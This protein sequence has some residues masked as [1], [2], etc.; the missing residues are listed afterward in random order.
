MVHHE[1]R[2]GDLLL[3]ACSIA[4]ND[5]QLHSVGLILGKVLDD[6]SQFG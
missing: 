2:Q 5:V 6:L 1:N 4:W 3:H